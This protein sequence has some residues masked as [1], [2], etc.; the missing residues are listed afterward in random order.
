MC[1]KNSKIG[2]KL[3]NLSSKKKGTE[4]PLVPLRQ[5]GILGAGIVDI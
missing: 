2:F 4:I 5:K 1:T 3:C